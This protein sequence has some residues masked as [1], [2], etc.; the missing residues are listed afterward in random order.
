MSL[1][2][3][4][5]FNADG[6]LKPGI[7]ADSPDY[8]TRVANGIEELKKSPDAWSGFLTEVA[9]NPATYNLLRAGLRLVGLTVDDNW[10]LFNAGI[11]RQDVSNI[12]SL[13]GSVQ[14]VSRSLPDKPYSSEYAFKGDDPRYMHRW[15]NKAGTIEYSRYP[16]SGFRKSR[17]P[18]SKGYYN[19]YRY[20]G[21]S[22]GGTATSFGKVFEKAK[23]V[24]ERVNVSGNPYNVGSDS[25]FAYESGWRDD[26][27]HSATEFLMQLE[28]GNV[29]PYGSD[30][31]FAYADGWRSDSGVSA[32][33]WLNGVNSDSVR[34]KIKGLELAQDKIM[35]VVSRFT[36][37]SVSVSA[38]SPASVLPVL[39]PSV[40]DPSVP[41]PSVPAPSV[42]A[43]SPTVPKDKSFL[44]AKPVTTP[45]VS[46]EGVSPSVVANVS[47]GQRDYTSL[48]QDV[49][50]KYPEFEVMSPKEAVAKG[51]ASKMILDA[52]GIPY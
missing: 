5:P 50:A 39:S 42:P 15:F 24:I 17:Y 48:S 4:S 9:K 44:N 45:I 43:P 31:Y 3:D 2:P 22:G 32:V 19:Y 10:T 16:A 20:V 46:S 25:Y 11:T 37:P 8:W 35:E 21:S 40:P 34:K 14:S 13:V 28:E 7:V 6:T 47:H 26:G 30:G 23:E 49:P 52:Y 36:S 38:S 12:G 41:A 1:S 33:E 27:G 51:L 18:N 29:Y